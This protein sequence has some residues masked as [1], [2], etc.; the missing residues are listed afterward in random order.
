VAETSGASM[1]GIAGLIVI[2]GVI[3]VAFSATPHAPGP[4][5]NGSYE[6]RV[7][8]T[9]GFWIE[10]VQYRHACPVHTDTRGYV[11]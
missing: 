5:N 3:V 10:M 7:P 1:Y 8:D 11:T 4:S 9:T 6:V 2:Y